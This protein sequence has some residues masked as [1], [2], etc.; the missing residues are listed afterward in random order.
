MADYISALTGP[1]MD[2]ALYDMASHTSEAWA[3]GTRNGIPVTSDDP[4]YNQYSKYWASR[5]ATYN[6]NAQAAA[7]RAEGAVDPG[8]AGA[9]FFDRTQSLTDAQKA[10]ART[11]I[12]A[13]SSTTVNPNLL[14]NPYFISGIVIN[15]RGFSSMANATG[16]TVDMWYKANV[17]GT[18]ST[19]VSG[20][21]VTNASTNYSIMSQYLPDP[22]FIRLAGKT[23]TASVQY[24]SGTVES[25]TFT[26]PS[27]F[28]STTTG[29]GSANLTNCILDVIWRDSGVIDFRIR[30]NPS[31]TVT[32][33]AAKL[34]FGNM[35]TLGDDVRIDR[36]E[37]WDKCRYYFR[38]IPRASSGASI[39]RLGIAQNS[40]TAV[41]PNITDGGAMYTTPTATFS[42]TI[43]AW[44][45]DGSTS[46]ITAFSTVSNGVGEYFLNATTTGLTRG[47]SCAIFLGSGAYIDLSALPSI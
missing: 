32:Y 22:A 25:F 2:E 6:T 16:Y 36:S 39:A 29:L 41:F 13:S 7:A 33:R 23:M 42:G 10:Q 38:R 8:T 4:T 19:S 26:V 15:Q 46:S 40:T 9:V 1:E 31:T 3:V 44:Y 47:Q 45:G 30:T 37:E 12:G 24:A 28:P 17:Y 5:A 18:L 21:T 11:N 27:P 20:L 35:C 34:E 14:I 43:S